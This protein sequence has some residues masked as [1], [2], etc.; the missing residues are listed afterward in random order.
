MIAF[1][2]MAR[3]QPYRKWGF[4]LCARIQPVCAHELQYGANSRTLQQPTPT[5][6]CGHTIVRKKTKK[7]TNNGASRCIRT[8]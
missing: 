5:H 8:K 3:I 2:C 6:G 7:D 1:P 4:S